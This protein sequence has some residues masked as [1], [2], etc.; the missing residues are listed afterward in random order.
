MFGKLLKY[1]MKSTMRIGIPFLIA[2]V[3]L[4]VLGFLN[5]LS[6]PLLSDLESYIYANHLDFLYEHPKLYSAMNLVSMLLYLLFTLFDTI[7]TLVLGV[8]IFAIV[9]VNLVNFYKSLITD[10]GYLTF[11]LPVKPLGILSSKCIN[12]VFWNTAVSSVSLIGILIIKAPAFLYSVHDSY[13]FYKKY[14]PD[15]TAMEAFKAAL[16]LGDISIG[17]LI[18]VVVLFFIFYF[19]LMAALQIFMFFTVFFG[20]VVAK[21]RKALASTLFTIGGYYLYYVLEQALAFSILIIS[22]SP[23]IFMEYTSAVT[24]GNLALIILST[25]LLISTFVVIGFIVLFFF[26]NKYLMEKKLNLP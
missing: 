15:Y 21:K 6:T 20:G 2:G 18:S 16:G 26:L 13:E 17:A 24:T 3:V 25:I 23:F 12:A 14:Y 9:I 8:L 22:L 4:T 1:D 19:F 7:A 11:T 5:A 10:E